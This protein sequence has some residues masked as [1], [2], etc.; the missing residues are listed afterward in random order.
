MVVTVVVVVVVVSWAKMRWR[1]ATVIKRP[2]T[3]AVAILLIYLEIYSPWC[4]KYILQKQISSA[5]RAVA[6]GSHVQVKSLHVPEITVDISLFHDQ[7]LQFLGTCADIIWTMQGRMCPYDWT[8]WVRLVWDFILNLDN[9][10]SLLSL[11]PIHEYMSKWSLAKSYP[12]WKNLDCLNL[13]FKRYKLLEY[14]IPSPPLWRKTR[15][16]TVSLSTE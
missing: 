4:L 3:T 1:P 9:P 10:S 8:V 12:A 11:F 2:V 16:N 5:S 13:D 14:A 6:T 7:I 15:A